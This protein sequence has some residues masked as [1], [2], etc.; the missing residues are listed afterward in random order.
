MSERA[1]AFLC[2]YNFAK[3]INLAKTC[4]SL[5]FKFSEVRVRVPD[6]S[7]IGGPFL[8]PLGKR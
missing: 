5:Q 8:V 6:D 4:Y 1:D 3:S 2:F 7:N